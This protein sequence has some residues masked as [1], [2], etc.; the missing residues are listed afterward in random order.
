MAVPLAR[1][2]DALKDSRLNAQEAASAQF[3]CE[4]TVPPLCGGTVI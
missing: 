4:K 3:G 1:R 2:H